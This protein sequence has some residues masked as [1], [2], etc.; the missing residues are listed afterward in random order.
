MQSSGF[1]EIFDLVDVLVATVVPCAWLAFRVFVGQAGAQSF[2]DRHGCEV[3]GCYEFDALPADAR[4]VSEP[5][6][7]VRAMYL[8]AGI[9]TIASP[10]RPR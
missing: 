8:Q 3:F 4:S 7:N 2:D 1:T 9:R 6:A 10:F 5:S